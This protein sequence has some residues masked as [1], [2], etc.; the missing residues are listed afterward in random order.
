MEEWKDIDG[1][2]GK[3]KISNIWNVKSI[4]YKRTW[5]E[6]IL[7][8]SKNTN[9]YQFV[10]FNKMSVQRW[11]IVHRLVAQAF[12]PNPENKSQVNHINGIKTDNR[13]ENLEWCTA[14]ENIQHAFRIWLCENNHYKANHP[15][16]WKF[17]KNHIASKSVNQYT[18]ELEFVKE[19]KS[20]VD[21]EIYLWID[22]ASI[23]KCCRWKNKT[24]W[25]F[26]WKFS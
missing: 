12:I 13:L 7:N 21:I 6:W 16:K 5:I 11:F 23:S 15:N 4:N 25:W 14:K 1:Y 24:A 10:S 20:S 26:I 9:W 18:K 19:W 8:P 3:Y 2:E 17:W 22:Q